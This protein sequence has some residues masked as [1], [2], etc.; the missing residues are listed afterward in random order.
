MLPLSLLSVAQSFVGL[1]LY[2]TQHII[3]KGIQ[4]WGVMRL[5]AYG[6]TAIEISR[7]HPHEAG[8]HNLLEVVKGTMSNLRPFGKMKEGILS[9][10]LV[11]TPNTTVWTWCL[12]FI[13]MN[14]NLLLKHSEELT[15]PWWMRCNTGCFCFKFLLQPTVIVQLSSQILTK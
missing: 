13:Y 12:V 11:T 3:I 5:H 7:C 9:P 6:D 4:I 14:M 1:S 10:S 15:L 8:R 2:C